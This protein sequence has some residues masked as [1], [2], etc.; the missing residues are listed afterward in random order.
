MLYAILPLGK[1][2]GITSILLHITH[3]SKLSIPLD[4]LGELSEEGQEATHKYFKEFRSASRM[5]SRVA[6]LTDI[7]NRFLTT[8]DPYMIH[9]GHNVSPLK[10]KIEKSLPE[11][12]ENLV[13]TFYKELPANEDDEV[14]EIDDQPVFF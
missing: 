7:M 9:L 5:S 10:S 14:A 13:L 12:V 1:G 8:T 2:I 11:D 4:H 3:S 6:N